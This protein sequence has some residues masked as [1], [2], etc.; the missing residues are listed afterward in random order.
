MRSRPAS[1]STASTRSRCSSTC[2]AGAIERDVRRAASSTRG[3]G[4]FTIHAVDHVLLGPGDAD[5]R[6]RLGLAASGLGIAEPELDELLERLA[7]DPETYFLSAEGHNRWR[8]ATPYEQFPMRRCVSIRALHP[9]ARVEYRRRDRRLPQP[10]AVARV[11][12][13]AARRST[14]P[15]AADRRRRQ[16]LARRDRR[17]RTGPARG[18]AGRAGA[19]PRLRRR[20]EPGD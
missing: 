1:D 11:P 8:G 3:S 4:G 13:L 18:R 7:D 6:A 17:A 14:R 2:T 9:G 16:R 19:K 5:H 12:R 10:R 15:P 20:N